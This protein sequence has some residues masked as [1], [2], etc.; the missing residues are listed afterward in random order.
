MLSF[1]TH[2]LH[3]DKKVKHSK[4]E[5]SRASRFLY[6]Q[7]YVPLSFCQLVLVGASPCYNGNM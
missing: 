3:Q 4:L 5:A 6:F 1:K 2:Q 7:S